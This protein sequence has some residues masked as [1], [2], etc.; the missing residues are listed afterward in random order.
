VSEHIGSGAGA[1]ADAHPQAERAA[2]GQAASSP[3]QSFNEWDPLEEVIVGRLEGAT[4][5]SWHPIVAAS[6]PRRAMRALSLARGFRYPRFLLEPA[7]EQLDGF[8]ALLTRA[9]VVV[10]RPDAVDHHRLFA[11]PDWRSRGYS[12]MFPRDGLFV[13]GDRIVEA[14]MAWP[15][16]Y[17]E[18][19][20]FRTLLKDYAR[21][22]AR[23]SAAPKPQL[24]DPLFRS[25]TDDDGETATLTEFE[26][27]FDAANFV[28]CGRDL[29]VMRNNL[30]NRMGIAWL[31]RHLGDQFRIHE[32]ESRVQ[33]PMHIDTAFMPLAPGK[34]LVNP[35]YVALDR[36]P[37]LLDSWDVLIAPEPEPIDD[38]LT[39]FVTMNDRWLSM[40][41]FMLDPKRVVVDPHYV[42]LVRAL[43]RWG[44]EP[45]PCP[46]LHFAALGGSFHCA[47]L[48]VRRRGTLQCYFPPRG[49]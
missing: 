46:F 25:A 34:V 48:D 39:R 21:R 5:P 10:R 30:V 35:E 28:R 6:I 26:P 42:G 17:F 27:V 29:F 40:N 33:T 41:V 7:Q 47:T 20:A 9:G 49:R 38:P 4:V 22:G 15:S 32:I 14:P 12:S 8:I 19:R 37:P 44:F 16:R 45:A 2:H 31:Q 11:T 3:V 36:L 24:T 43:E 13:M 23:W 1:S 18:T